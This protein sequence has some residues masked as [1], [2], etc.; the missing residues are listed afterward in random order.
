VIV[1]GCAL[2]VRSFEF[3]VFGALFGDL[4]FSV[5][6]GKLGVNFLL[7]F[8][9]DA[10]SFAQINQPPRMASTINAKGNRIIDIVT[11][12]SYFRIFAIVEAEVIKRI[13]E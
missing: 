4:N 8:R 11:N 10:F 3:A 2:P 6:L 7:T 1:N 12:R 9:T 5:E 13:E